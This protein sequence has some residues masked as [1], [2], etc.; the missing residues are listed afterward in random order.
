M[1]A[2]ETGVTMASNSLSPEPKRPP[3]PPGGKFHNEHVVY[4]YEESDSLLGELVDFIG[5]ALRTGDAALIIATKVHLDGLRQRLSARGFDIPIAEKQK[6]YIALDAAEILAQVMANG[7]PDEARFAQI[8]GEIIGPISDLRKNGH[9]GIAVFGEMVSLLWT[10]GKSEAAIRLEELWNEL[11]NVYSFSLRCAYP[12]A[13]FQG[14]KNAGPLIRVC[15][16]HSAVLFG[17]RDASFKSGSGEMAPRL[18]EARFRLFVDAVQDYAIYTMDEQGHVSSWNAGAQRIKGYAISEIIGKHFSV[19]YTQEDLQSGKPQRDLEIAARDGR[20]EDEGWRLRKDGSRFWADTV[21]TAVRNDKG[22]LLGFGKVTRDFT[23]KLAANEALRRQI[24][25]KTEAQRKL[26]ESENSLRQLSLR[27]LQTQDEERR[28]IGRDLHDSV[29][30]YLVGLKMK[31]DSLRSAAEKNGQVEAGEFSECGQL[32]EDAIKEVRTISYLLYPPMLEEL[33]LK[34]AIPWYLE[35]FTKRSGIDTTFEVSPDFD[36]IPGG[37]E[38]ALFRVLQESLTNV[39]RHSGS[40][41]AVVRL[42]TK[43]GSVILQIIDHGKSN[44]SKSLEDASVNWTGSFGVGLRGMSERVGQLGGNL[45]VSRTPEGTTVTA[46]VPIPS[47]PQ[48]F[49]AE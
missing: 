47:S 39:H 49:D 8:L 10:E 11:A 24:V 29:G 36:R 22:K 6:K 40:S 14:V 48:E 17:Q 9:P 12:M 7:M 27:L 16:E 26:H 33:G 31:L 23:E 15:G 42:Q 4:F 32:A 25:E 37:M 13:N 5:P 3:P 1:L 21:I 44:Q 18:S 41:T 45:E 34:S 30:Q 38:L 43:D 28:R 20:V 2:R 35:G 46:T 19:F